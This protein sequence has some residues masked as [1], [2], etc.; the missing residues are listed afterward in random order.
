MKTFLLQGDSITDF[1]RNRDD[2]NGGGSCGYATLTAAKLGFAYPGEIRVINR[3]VS[4]DRTVDLYARIKR[5]F[6]DVKPDYISI[7][8]GVND[9]WHD[10]HEQPNGVCDEK[11]RRVYSMIIEELQA[12][13]PGVKIIILEPFC[14]KAGATEG[15]WEIFN[16]EVRKRA[17]SAKAVAEKYGLKFVPLQ[18]KLDA[19]CEKAEPSFWLSDG[20]HP[21]PAGHELIARELCAA[22]EEIK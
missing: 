21:A 17:V 12:E 19:A 20:V 2:Y 9:V 3:G 22:F 16:T 7:L 14:L 13:L 11:Y 8:I 18:D 15:N 4:G 5:D 10:F 1:G 6:I